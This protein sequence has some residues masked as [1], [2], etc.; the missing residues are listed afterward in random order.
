MMERYWEVKPNEKPRVPKEIV[1]GLKYYLTIGVPPKFACF[2]RKYSIEDA[3]ITI[4]GALSWGAESEKK[5][6]WNYYDLVEFYNN[7]DPI[8]VFSPPLRLGDLIYIKEGEL[9]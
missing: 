8:S 1:D 5:H 7:S 2:C 6:I 4:E 9:R 3:K